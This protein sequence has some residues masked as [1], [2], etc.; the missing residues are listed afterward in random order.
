MKIRNRLR[1]PA[2]S[3]C[4]FLLAGSEE[5]HDSLNVVFHALLCSVWPRKEDCDEYTDVYKLRDMLRRYSSFIQFPI[6]LWAEKT[7][8]EQV[9]DEEAPAPENPEDEPKMKTVSKTTE[10]VCD[11][12]ELASWWSRCCRIASVG[13]LSCN[14]I[15]AE[16]LPACLP[17][18]L[19]VYLPACLPACLFL[20]TTFL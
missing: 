14:T 4:L 1:L 10:G 7:E 20:L 16:A 8:Y 12:C 15:D 11:G 2:P 3:F 17:A 5:T 18:C 13:S 6:E 9:V 19:L